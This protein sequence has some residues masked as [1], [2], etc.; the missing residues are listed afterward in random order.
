MSIIATAF[1]S[2]HGQGHL[3]EETLAPPQ[4]DELLIKT[5]H[6]G[7]SKGTETLVFKGHVPK[8]EHDRMRAPFQAGTFDGAVKYGYC[9]VGQVQAG[10]EAWVGARV[11]CLHPHQDHYVVPIS[12]VYRLPDTLPSQRA[13]LAANM[14]TAVNGLADA[15]LDTEING[16]ITQSVSVMGAGVVGCLIAHLA[17]SHG[18][19]VELVDINPQK[20]AV[21]HHLGLPFKLSH[22]AT[23][24]RAVVIHT[25]ATQAGLVQALNLAQHEGLIIEMS[26]FGTQS[27]CLPLGEAFHAKRLTLRS[28]QV[29]TISPARQNS[30]TYATRFACALNALE[31][32]RLD[33]LITGHSRFADL[34]KVMAAL[35]QGDQETLC[36]VI[37]YL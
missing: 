33:G 31:D 14:E 5:L 35:A 16:G 17:H 9:N 34:P 2:D 30:W 21:A 8:S 36:H 10:P 4:A 6:S 32:S 7:I 24:E 28:S 23:P 37:D 19:E 13:V 27:P 3:I 11:F 29:G 12:S 18:H 26:W 25:S 22:E 20:K 15:G 1:W